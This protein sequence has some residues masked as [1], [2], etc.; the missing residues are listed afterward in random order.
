[1]VLIVLIVG[2]VATVAG[3]TA[4]YWIGAQGDSEI[5]PQTDTTDWNYWSKY[6]IY[7]AVVENGTTVGYK[8]VGFDGAVLENVIIP[9]IA[10]GGRLKNSN[11]SFTTITDSLLVLKVGNST[12]SGT[13]DKSIPVTLTLPTTVAVE[14]GAFMGLYNLTTVKVV[15]VIGSDSVT[16]DNSIE[17]G[18][19]AFFGCTNVTKFIAATNVNFTVSGAGVDFEALKSNTGLPSDLLRSA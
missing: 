6:F 17:I 13:T 12:F 14:P 1:M 7:E 11:G 8:T 3:V 5:A 4:A 9:R 15:S 10:T 18:T 19:S 16:Y 2:T